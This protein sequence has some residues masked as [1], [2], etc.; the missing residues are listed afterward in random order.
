M[1]VKHKSP[2]F[3]AHHWDGSEKV[4][5]SLIEW[6]GKGEYIKSDRVTAQHIRIFNRMYEWCGEYTDLP[7]D[8]YPTQWILKTEIGEFITISKDA[9][10]AHY[11]HI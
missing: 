1:F 7:T 11:E 8:I 5:K 2:L 4:A 6:M 3:E 10:E 9:F